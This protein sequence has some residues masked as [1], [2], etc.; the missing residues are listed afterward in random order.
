M[1]SNKKTLIIGASENSERYANKA[2]HSLIRH[3]HTVMML[4]NKAGEIEGEIIQT[5]TPKFE[6]IDTVTLYIN[7]KNQEPYYDYILALKPK[8]IIFN[9]GTENPILT[10]LAEQNGIE[11][12]VACTLVLLAIGKY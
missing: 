11:A 6:A 2:F 5:G 9:P 7:P 12:T 4:G 8:R 10:Q 3:G 1:L